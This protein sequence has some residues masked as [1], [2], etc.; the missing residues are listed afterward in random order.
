MIK[1]KKVNLSRPKTSS[2][3]AL[4]GAWKDLDT[5]KMIKYIYEGRKD[6]GK[7]KNEL[8]SF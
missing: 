3:M 1:N 2:I 5:D 8:Q 4:A 6:K 7:I